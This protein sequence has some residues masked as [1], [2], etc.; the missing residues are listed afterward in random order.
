MEEKL[1]RLSQIIE[2]RGIKI[3]KLAEKM[4]LTYQGLKY[5]LKGERPFKWGEI[6]LLCRALYL[7]NDERDALLFYE[8]EED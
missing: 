6:C 8:Q 5:K 7:S 3:N 1:K 2:E 4:G